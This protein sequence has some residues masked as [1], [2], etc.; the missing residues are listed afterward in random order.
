MY[1]CTRRFSDYHKTV[2]CSLR[3]KNSAAGS[4]RRNRIRDGMRHASLIIDLW[5][6]DTEREGRC[7]GAGTGRGGGTGD[8]CQGISRQQPPN[9]AVSFAQR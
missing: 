4:R 9:Q 7:V 6:L 1:N 8:E 5:L 2:N 3:L